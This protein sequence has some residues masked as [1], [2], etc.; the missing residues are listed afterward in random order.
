MLDLCV[1]EI[2]RPLGGTTQSSIDSRTGSKGKRVSFHVLLFHKIPVM[3]HHVFQ[4]NVT[5]R[6]LW[7]ILGILAARVLTV[8][9]LPHF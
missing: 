9:I 2:G 4:I 8:H 7:Y 3:E 1:K 6:T 5:T